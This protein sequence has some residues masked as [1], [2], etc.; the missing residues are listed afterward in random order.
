M[1]DR[2][3]DCFRQIQPLIADG[4]SLSEALFVLSIPDNPAS[5][6]GRPFAR[7]RAHKRIQEDCAALLKFL[8]A[9]LPLTAAVDRL[10]PGVHALT[11]ARLSGVCGASSLK[12][13]FDSVLADS[14]RQHLLRQRLAAAAV[15]PAVLTLAL[16]LAGLWLCFYGLPALRST[17]LG[18]VPA[19]RE[20]LQM[21]LPRVFPVSLALIA[22]LLCVATHVRTTREQAE[23]WQL[24]SSLDK[25]GF[26]LN[27]AAELCQTQHWGLAAA[28]GIDSFR[29]ALIQGRSAGEA[30]QRLPGTHRWFH[31][32][33]GLTRQGQVRPLLAR[34]ARR[35]QQR[36]EN[37]YA[38]LE[39]M[40]EP[41][42]L[43]FCGILM[44]GF[45]TGIVIPLINGIGGSL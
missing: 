43:T 23:L 14:D 15:Y 29:R 3:I 33:K 2:M 24:L 44:L 21:L 25:S 28:A 11:L 32:L 39:R 27:E 13:A 42:F 37:L 4:Q 6:T 30:L 5:V 18:A 9:G 45:A 31:E 38:A 17:G 26:T 16:C 10:W 36:L 8:S 41:V 35:E 1:K 34:A 22:G 40:A 19:G 20:L 7:A 12:E